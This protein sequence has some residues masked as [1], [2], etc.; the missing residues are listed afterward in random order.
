MKRKSIYYLLTAMMACIYMGGILNTQF[1][2]LMKGQSWSPRFGWEL[3]VAGWGALFYALGSLFL[4]PLS[5]RWGRV[6]CIFWSCIIVFL[7]QAVMG[8]NLLG[9][10]RLWHFFLYWGVNCLCLAL[11]F[12]SVEG[13][14]SEY[15][16]HRMP[17]ARRL[18]IYCLSWAS[19]DTIGTFM[20]GYIKETRGAQ[21]MF[22]ILAIFGIA[23]VVIIGMDWLKH[24]YRKFGDRDVGE[25]DIRPDAPF[26]ASLARIGIFFGS[27]AFSALSAAFPRFGRDFH[28]LTEGQI[29]NILSMNLFVCAV[30]FM[31][32]PL[33]K[34]W[35]YKLRWQIGLQGAMLAGL[36]FFLV[37]PS[38]SVPLLRLGLILFGFGW[39]TGYFFSIYYSL[40]V[41]RNHARSGGIHEAVL[42]LGNLV[43]PF[44]AVGAIEIAGRTGLVSQSRLGVMAILVAIASV[45]VSIVIQ[46][47]MQQRRI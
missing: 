14:F 27:M 40:L 26:H 18:G 41:P 12:T 7:L 19:G 9:A 2:I 45:L 16:D 10:Y 35:H 21:G 15:Q 24:G 11:Y 4:A 25:A 3:I 39:S 37:A 1:I 47:S 23:A 6:P 8:W 29:G 33:F 28:K 17:L 42:G 13:L 43:G 38:G 46:L 30:T 5:D 20:T 44:A 36:A 22:R 32:F 31:V 34:G